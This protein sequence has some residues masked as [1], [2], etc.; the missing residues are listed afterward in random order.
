M[1]GVKRGDWVAGISVA[2]IA[3]PQSLAYAEIAGMP[4]HLGLYAA[5]IPPIV[6][7]FFASSRYLQTGPVA[8]T[9]LLTYGALAILETPGTPAYVQSGVLLALIVGVMRVVLGLLRGGVVAYLMSQPVL[10][11]F[12]SAA[13]ILIVASQV[14]VVLGLPRTGGPLPGRALVALGRPDQW[15]LAAI[16]ISVTTAV[17]MVAGRRIHRLFP[18]VLIAVVLGVA[19]TTLFQ[20]PVETLENIPRGMPSLPT[21]IPWSRFTELLLPGAVIAVVGFAEPAVVA[22]TLA[23]Q[24]RQSWNP[25]REFVSQGMANLSSAMVGAFPVGGSFSRSAIA[26]LAGA[27]TRFTGLIGGVIVFATLPFAGIL[28]SLPRA[29]LGA[30][31]IVATVRLIRV[32]ALVRMVRV[33]WGQSAVAWVTFVSTLALAP[34]VDHG[35]LL[36]VALATAVHLRRESMIRLQTRVEQGTLVLCPSGVLYFGSAPG[37]S[38]ALVDELAAHDDDHI[39]RVVVD[40]SELGRVDYTGALALQSFVD[41][42]A[43]AGLETRLRGI[44]DHALGTLTR[45]LGEQLDQLRDETG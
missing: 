28:E 23:A 1:T 19:A 34:R 21:N 40:L 45:S 9:G 8:M 27:Q 22:R 20:I 44:P 26:R 31:V 15:S 29:V 24:D 3:I 32:T 17:I 42:C 2:A 16:A 10:L 38:Q 37:L 6:A 7:A 12:S 35:L 18:G 30:V 14:E 36:G 5:A 33:S 39:T 43:G 4:V 25:D 11:G 13:A 41:D